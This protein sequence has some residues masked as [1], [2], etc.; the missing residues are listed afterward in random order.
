MLFLIN[1]QMTN[2]R[3]EGKLKQVLTK[4][5][6]STDW[7]KRSAMF[8]KFQ[9]LQEQNIQNHSTVNSQMGT[10]FKLCKHF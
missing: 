4:K 2:E 1:N 10:N 8:I 7:L 3:K 9:I 5:N 6:H